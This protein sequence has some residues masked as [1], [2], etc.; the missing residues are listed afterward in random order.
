MNDC[1]RR[2]VERERE[3]KPQVS[4][5]FF[6]CRLCVCSPDT[7]Q[8]T[9]LHILPLVHF[10]LPFIQLLSPF[11]RLLN[12]FICIKTHE[13]YFFFV[14]ISQVNFRFKAINWRWV[15]RWIAIYWYALACYPMALFEGITDTEPSL[16][17]C[18]HCFQR[19]G[20]WAQPASFY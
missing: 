12:E 2:L 3:K 5:L 10:V 4:S 6:Y 9:Q 14:F 15:W 17:S 7:F 13:A 20:N 11:L 8:L 19:S 16:I 18:L 1:K